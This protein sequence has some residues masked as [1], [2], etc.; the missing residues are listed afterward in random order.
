MTYLTEEEFNRHLTHMSNV[1]VL[2]VDTEGTLTHPFSE[3]W[4]LSYSAKGVSEYF[5][6]NHRLG[7][8]LPQS[9]LPK[10]KFVIENHPCLGMH[11]SKH[12]L[13][14][15]RN[16]DIHYTGKFYDT[17]LMTHMLNENLFSKELDYLGKLFN[18]GG[19]KRSEDMNKIIKAFGWGYVPIPTMREYAGHDAVLTEKIFEEAYPH[20]IAED[21]D[22]ELWDIE[23]DFVRVLIKMEDQ[24]IPIDLNFCKEELEYGL[25]VMHDIQQE[26][27]FDPAKATELGK[28]LLEDMKLPVIK[29]S[30]KTGK[31]SFD[32]EVMETY[33]EL[34]EFRGDKSAE[35][36][37][38]FRGWQKTTSSNYTPY[39]NL[40]SPDGRLRPSFKIHGTR[41]GR[42]SCEKPNLQQ[43]PRSSLKRWNG[44]LKKA[45]ISNEG[46][47][48]WEFDHSQLEMRLGLYYAI[49]S[50]KSG[51]GERELVEIFAD[52]SRDVF[53]EMSKS[54]NMGGRQ[55]TKTFQYTLQYLGGPRRI[56]TVFGVSLI[57]GQA[58]FDNYYNRFPGY[59]AVAKQAEKKAR[60]T[61]F[62]RYWTGRRRHFDPRDK[63]EFRKA[64]SSLTQGGGFEIV[65]RNIIALDKAG[66]NNNECHMDLQVHDSIRVQIEEGKEHIYH[67]E[68]KRVMEDVKLPQDTGVRFN[69][70]IGRWGE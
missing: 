37:L 43:I 28:F 22:D 15:L 56:S 26:L 42:T 54:L 2:F 55:K 65:K 33:D 64:S 35:Q 62:I 30:P 63:D 24:G 51:V 18:F 27:G 29:K 32:K 59:K 70:K 40:I 52:P 61:G 9:W 47:I 5:A 45:F 48:P 53:N 60:D 66:L 1:P 14:A 39:L 36:I 67:P 69:V 10:L 25:G 50:G 4:G 68:I 11:G 8:N 57:A 31:P 12:D 58:L 34:L 38:T 7:E 21:F 44:K 19:K 20:F 16:L 23:Q 13:R 49:L 46:F 6:F 3:T 17:M 41:S